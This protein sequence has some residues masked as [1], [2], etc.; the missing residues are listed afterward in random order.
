MKPSL[1]RATMLPELTIFGSS[2]SGSE[3]HLRSSSWRGKPWRLLAPRRWWLVESKVRVDG[4]TSLLVGHRSG[5]ERRWIE[6]GQAYSASGY[7]ARRRY[8]ACPVDSCRNV[9]SVG[10][11]TMNWRRGLFRLWIVGTVL[12]VIAV[13]FVSYS[14]IKAQFDATARKPKT[15]IH[16]SIL[17]QFRQEYPQYNDLNDAQLADALY[18]K[19]YS[20]I[21]REQFDRKIAGSNTKII[22]FQGRL[23]VFPADATDDEIAATLANEPL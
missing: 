1:A 13:A 15:I 16:S 2:V 10:Q 23:H 19:L 12:F 6:R 22:E 14:E 18:K 8:S 3:R 11:P 9:Y 7:F 21:P 5:A 17:A 20:D 4:Q